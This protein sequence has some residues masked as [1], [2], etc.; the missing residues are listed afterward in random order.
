VSVATGVRSRQSSRSSFAESP[1]TNTV[2]ASPLSGNV[3]TSPPH[4]SK[5]LISVFHGIFSQK[6]S[7]LCLKKVPTFKLSVTWS[8]LNRFSEF[9]RC[10]KAYEICYKTHTTLPT[11]PQ[12]VATLPWEIKNSN[13]CW[14]SARI[15]ENANKLHF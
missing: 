1:P 15:V 5:S 9:L 14:Y 6:S 10:W 11:S 12:F 3:I 2:C 7:T 13:F 4:V 8:N